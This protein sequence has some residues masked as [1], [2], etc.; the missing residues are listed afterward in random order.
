LA[1]R[2]E[3]V[4]GAGCVRSHVSLI[5]TGLVSVCRPRSSAEDAKHV[6]AGF[7]RRRTTRC[8]IGCGSAMHPSCQKTVA[9]SLN[10]R[11]VRSLQKMPFPVSSAGPVSLPAAV[12]ELTCRRMRYDRALRLVPR[13]RRLMDQICCPEPA[14]RRLGASGLPSRGYAAW[15]SSRYSS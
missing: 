11:W 14:N 3:I 1:D 6:H 8:R 4:G 2:D 15:R 5:I 12:N 9:Q 7:V 13:C 10:P